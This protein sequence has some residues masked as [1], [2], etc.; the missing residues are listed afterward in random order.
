M[1]DAQL[2][3]KYGYD[4]EPYIRT[5]NG[6]A[7]R[8]IAAECAAQTE[9][10]YENGFGEIVV[11]RFA[12]RPEC[13]PS[14]W[15]WSSGELSSE[16]EMDAFSSAA[17]LYV[18]RGKRPPVNPI[19]SA[20][21]DDWQGQDDD[22]FRAMSSGHWLSATKGQPIESGS[23]CQEYYPPDAAPAQIE[24]ARAVLQRLAALND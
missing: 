5:Y 3:A 16:A 12:P 11:T 14:Y 7:P 18:D 20:F 6:T 15:R 9:A 8:R 23:W 2:Q 21:R 19:L 4:K 17:Y 13:I 22:E 24:H 1:T 10:R